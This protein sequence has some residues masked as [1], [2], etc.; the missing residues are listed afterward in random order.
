MVVA[1]EI[2]FG[3]TFDDVLLEP[4]HSTILP[5]ATSVHTRLA[6]SLNLA[7][8]LISAAMDTVTESGLAIAMAQ[9]G[10]L[11]IVHRSLKSTATS[12]V[13]LKYQEKYLILLP[14]FLDDH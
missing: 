2:P 5:Q 7:I 10:G 12:N 8:P 3:L 11:G 4:C 9:L 13:S 1:A 14:E 6:P